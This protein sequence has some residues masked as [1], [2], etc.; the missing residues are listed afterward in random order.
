MTFNDCGFCI[1]EKKD[2]ARVLTRALVYTTRSVPRDK[3]GSDDNGLS[4]A[5]KHKSLRAKRMVSP[6]NEIFLNTSRVGHCPIMYECFFLS[7][8]SND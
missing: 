8:H 1:S 6:G 4:T 7:F 5:A 2:L 3:E